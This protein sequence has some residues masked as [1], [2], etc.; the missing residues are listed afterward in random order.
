MKT[1]LLAIAIL[2]PAQLKEIDPTCDATHCKF[3]HEQMQAIK[4]FQQFAIATIQAQADE[5][6][7][8]KAGNCRARNI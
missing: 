7:K 3:T 2:V 5:I 1:L 8:L 4:N 6:E